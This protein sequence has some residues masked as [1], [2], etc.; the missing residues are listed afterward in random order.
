LLPVGEAGTAKGFVFVRGASISIIGF[1][2]SM[3]ALT[4][5]IALAAIILASAAEIGRSA[6]FRTRNFVVTAATAGEAETVAGA[7]EEYRRKLAIY[8]IGHPLK[9]WFRPC[10]LTVESG[11]YGASGKTTFQFMGT[12]VSNWRM[13]VRGT[14]ER[15]LDSV[16]PHEINHTIF[17]CYFRRPLPRWADEGA[18]RLFEHHSEQRLQLNLLQSIISSPREFIPLKRLLSMKEYPQGHRPMLIMYA[19]GFALVDFLIQQK[20]REVYLKF[21]ADG[22]RNNNQWDAPIRQHYNHAGIDALEKDWRAWVKAGMPRYDSPTEEMLAEVPRESSDRDVAR[23]VAFNN[24]NQDMFQEVRDVEDAQGFQE[25]PPPPPVGRMARQDD[26]FEKRPDDD[27]QDRLEPPARPRGPERSR[28][29]EPNHTKFSRNRRTSVQAPEPQR[30]PSYR[31]AEVNPEF[32][33]RGLNPSIS[34]RFQLEPT[35]HRGDAA[36]RRREINGV[37]WERSRETGS[38][39]QWADFPGQNG[40]F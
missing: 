11:H 35:H 15:I 38:T 2:P 21:L 17:A 34:E 30:S 12:E 37:P 25:I 20:G 39:P 13:T 4:C 16:L 1:G 40:S 3:D 8:W 33:R 27:P 28:F 7:A 10:R 6:T 29:Y 31:T 24:R 23:P 26:V 18:A 22:H 9:N 36:T 5:R 32:E 19:E 14:P